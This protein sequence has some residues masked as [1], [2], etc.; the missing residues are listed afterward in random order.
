[1]DYPSDLKDKEWLLIERYFRP[2]DRRENA[3]KHLRKQIVDAILYIGKSGAQWRRLP[4]DFPPWQTVYD[5]FSHWNKR[6]VWEAVRGELNARHRKKSPDV[7]ARATASS[8]HTASRPST[9][10]TNGASMVENG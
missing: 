5:H 9:T 7:P 1:M 8:I 3:R 6:G 4:K 10:A 2:K